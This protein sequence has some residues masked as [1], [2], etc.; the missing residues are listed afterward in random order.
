MTIYFTADLHLG[1]KKPQLGRIHLVRQEWQNRPVDGMRPEYVMM[2]NFRSTLTKRDQ[3]W[4]LGDLSAGGSQA[5][6]DALATLAQLRTDTGAEFHL[7]PGNH[8]G[9]HPQFRTAKKWWPEYLEVFDTI[10]PFA[11]RKIAGHNVCLSHYPYYGDHTEED[12]HPQW[13][14][15]DTGRWLLHG[16]THQ[17]SPLTVL[18]WDD[19]GLYSK[20]VPMH[21]RHPDIPTRFENVNF[22]ELDGTP[23]RVVQPGDSELRRTI[24]VGVDAWGLWPVSLETIADLITKLEG[25]Q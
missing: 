2:Q 23:T 6:R 19:Q 20:L 24:N 21:T 15:R 5:Q 14:L 22:R 11:A 25:E 8:D 9:C 17:S 10:M 18:Q 16:H 1:H 12:R 3:L 4:I 7:I 13:R